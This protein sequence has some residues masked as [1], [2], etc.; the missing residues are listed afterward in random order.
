MDFQS[1]ARPRHVS[2]DFKYDVLCFQKFY[3]SIKSCYL[4]NFELLKE[5]C[6]L[7]VLAAIKVLRK[8]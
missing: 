2:V 1:L 4:R 8:I 5:L 6:I 7:F 3:V